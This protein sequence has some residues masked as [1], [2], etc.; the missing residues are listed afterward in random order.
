MRTRLYLDPEILTKL[1]SNED[2]PTTRQILEELHSQGNLDI[3]LWTSADNS[4][5][6]KEYIQEH[7]LEHIVMGVIESHTI[8][9]PSECDVIADTRPEILK[10][11]N[12]IIL[13]DSLAP[14]LRYFVSESKL[15]DP[16]YVAINSAEFIGTLQNI[17]EYF[18]A[19]NITLDLNDGDFRSPHYLEIEEIFIE[20]MRELQKDDTLTMA[21]HKD[22]FVV[23]IKE[24]GK[25]DFLY[26]WEG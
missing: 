7:Y 23:T 3:I 6:L 12:P 1:S 14:L 2:Y 21:S 26:E 4:H 16:V 11:S 24:D 18:E 22:G 25:F 8:T 5:N 9:N 20:L 10:L 15:L 17:L 19:E 13:K